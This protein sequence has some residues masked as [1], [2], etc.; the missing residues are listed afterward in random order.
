MNISR[1][2]SSVF[3]KKDCRPYHLPKGS[4]KAQNLRSN[5]KFKIYETGKKTLV[6]NYSFKVTLY[7]DE[8]I[9]IFERLLETMRLLFLT[10]LTKLTKNKL[11]REEFFLKYCKFTH[12]VIRMKTVVSA[13]KGISVDRISKG[14]KLAFGKPEGLAIKVAKPKIPE[15]FIVLYFS[16]KYEKYA[17]SACTLMEKVAI[18]SPL[19][20]RIVILQKNPITLN[21]I[22]TPEDL[23]ILTA[24]NFFDENFRLKMLL[25]NKISLNKKI[26][27]DLWCR[28]LKYLYPK[29]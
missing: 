3:A 24:E 6:D 25:K 16:K 14:M 13:Q 21:T 9:Q 4:D 28:A 22:F 2:H 7:I 5:C 20:K 10:K 11:S 17:E 23:K 15:P 8:Y 29:N 1:R 19:R 18:K 12:H 26:T 27:K